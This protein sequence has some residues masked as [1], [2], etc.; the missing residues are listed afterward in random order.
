MTKSNLLTVASLILSAVAVALSGVAVWMAVKGADVRQSSSTSFEA[1]ARAYLLENPE[2]LLESFQRLEDEQQ[3]SEENEIERAL[4]ENADEIFKS[5]TSPVAGNVDGDVTIVEFFDYNCPYCRKAVPMLAEAL[6]ADD[7][8]RFVFKEWPIL[9]PGSE[10]AARAALA[11]QAQ[12]KYEAFHKAMMDFSGS[13]DEAST[14]EVARTVGLDVERLKRDM[15]A[16]A[17]RAELDRNFAL[18][19]ELRINGTPAFV[20]GDEIARGLI[21]LTAMQQLIAGARAKAGG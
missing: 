1:Q 5:Q 21:D 2:V 14:L 10:F 6:A 7:K 20:I 18:A 15:E 4:R 17:I 3:A 16:E 19:G 11:S 9:G 13:I 12:G 8:L